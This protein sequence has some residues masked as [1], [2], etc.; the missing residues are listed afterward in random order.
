MRRPLPKLVAMLACCLAFGLSTTS[1]GGGPGGVNTDLVLLGF[2]QPEVAGVALNQPLVFTFSTNVDPDS[3]TPDSLRVVGQK[4]VAPFTPIPAFFEQTVVDGNLVALIPRSPNFDDYTDCGLL[5]DGEYGV[6]MPVFPGSFVTIESTD[7]R[8]LIQYSDSGDAYTYTF[9]TVTADRLFSARTA[10]VETFR[11]LVHGLDPREGGNSDDFGCLQNRNNS[12]FVAP[13]I[14][15]PSAGQQTFSGPGARLLCLENEG[16]PRVVPELCVPL[17]DQRAV[18]TPAA[19]SN[20]VGR[21]DLPAIVVSINEQ[22]DPVTVTPYIPTAKLSVNVQLW[23][24]A[25]LDGT[26]LV[27]PEQIEVN[28]PLLV[29]RQGSTQIILVPAGPVLQGIYLVNT[30][31]NVRDLAQNRLRT[32]D[33]PNL[34]GSVYQSLNA[35]LGARVPEGWRLYFQTLQLPN[36]ASAIAESFGSNLGEWGDSE[37]IDKEPGVFTQT[38]GG[39]LLSPIPGIVPVGS[40]QPSFRLLYGSNPGVALQVGQST[41]AN[42]NNGY[43]FLNLASLEVNTDA[44]SGLGRLKAVHKPYRGTGGD[45]SVDTSLPPFTAGSGDTLSLTTTPGPGASINGDGIYEYESFHLRAGDTL[46]ASG[47]QPLLI[48]CRGDFIVEGTI[49]L[50]GK[51]GRFG[52]DTDGTSD[53]TNPGSIQAWGFG[54]AAGPGG[55]AGGRGGGANLQPATGGGVLAGADGARAASILAEQSLGA[56]LAGTNALGSGGGGAGHSFAGGTGTLPDG[57]NAGNGGSGFGTSLLEVP[58]TDFKPDRGYQANAGA[59]GG[60][61]GGGGSAD[62]DGD[63]V[64]DNG[65]EMAGGGGGGGGALWVIAGG[66]V[67]VGASGQILADGGDGGSTYGAADIFVQNG[68]NPETGDP[69]PAF[70]IVVGLQPTAGPPSGRGGPGGGGAGGSI[71]LVGEQGITVQLGA[72]LSAMGGS[73]GGN[74]VTDGGGN[75]TMFGGDGAD[76]R[77][78]LMDMGLGPTVT[79]TGATIQPAGTITTWN[80][81]VDLAS[82]GVATWIDLFVPTVDWAPVVGG[83]P[84]VPFAT[85]NFDFLTTTAG[86]VQGVGGDFDA[87][88]EYQGA[89]DI[90]PAPGG[91]FPPSSGTAVSPWTSNINLIDG[92]R[93]FRWRCRF[94]VR[95]GYPSTGLSALPLPALLD[96]TIPLVK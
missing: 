37:S 23:R 49:D 24:V 41:T 2:N 96:L 75:P 61:G 5:W 31:G 47:T 25:L 81:T 76:G 4:V 79:T 39:D 62:D 52:L 78:L 45:G 8:P 50:R 21:V 32:N 92:K 51:D 74:G 71:C 30:L 6:S 54:G 43:R 95:Q 57:S 88:L 22:V 28:K 1:C 77:I 82:V 34:T 9:R 89:D 42:W 72:F 60:P 70:D 58:L 85:T 68:V 83:V 64:S 15:E 17:H 12:L 7:G 56:G 46:S 10:F 93:F 48:L 91:S 40:S 86:L 11:P 26:P 65:D 87:L 59:T 55:G 3:I 66:Q 80:P 73:G 13:D 69:D 94:F 14:T 38:S 35:N 16:V 44:D 53:F 20:N 36:T 18:G 33:D 67:T 19:G 29:Q 27:P 90:S 84:Q 63:S